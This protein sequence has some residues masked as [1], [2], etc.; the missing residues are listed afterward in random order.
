MNMQTNSSTP[1]ITTIQGD[2]YKIDL[3]EN[4]KGQPVA[5]YYKL[6]TVGK[7]KGQYKQLEGYYFN[8][9]AKRS[10]WVEKKVA[11][12]N[13]RLQEKEKEKTI[14]KEIRAN[15]DHGFAVGQVYY[16]S[17]GYDQTN[18]DFYEVVEVKEKSVVLHPIGGNIVPGSEG[19]DCANVTPDPSNI[20]GP[21]F[22]KT[23]QFYLQTDTNAPVFYLKADHGWLNLYDQAKEGVYKS[24]YR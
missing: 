14:K 5:R 17:W 2:N 4:A 9:E 8:N 22:L 20:I 21:P 16:D 24:W 18:I 3:T 12:L 13:K 11:A 6:I 15:M 19:M 7:N 1:P 10:D 23:I